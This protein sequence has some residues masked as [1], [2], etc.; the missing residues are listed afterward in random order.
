M[1]RIDSIN[2]KWQLYQISME[3][4]EGMNGYSDD[5]SSKTVT[6]TSEAKE[7][8]IKAAELGHVFAQYELARMYENGIGGEADI[9]KAIQWYKTTASN[10]IREAKEALKRLLG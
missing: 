4:L 6:M 8:F 10:N 1:S 9:E 5:G 7:C 2:D 3:Y